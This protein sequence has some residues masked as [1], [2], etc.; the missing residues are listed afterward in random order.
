MLDSHSYAKI[1]AY[2]SVKFVEIGRGRGI[3]CSLTTQIII[4]SNI[5]KS[6][7]MATHEGSVSRVISCVEAF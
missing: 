7:G 4:K 5:F 6:M 3:E 1:L 2:L